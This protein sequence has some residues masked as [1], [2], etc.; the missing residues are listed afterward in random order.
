M[1]FAVMRSLRLIASS[2]KHFINSNVKLEPSEYLYL[3]TGMIQYDSKHHLAI[4]DRKRQTI[5]PYF[6]E[7][8]LSFELEP[9]SVP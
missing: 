3:F 2:M 1:K 8:E 5:R 6:A 4:A 9:A 7:V